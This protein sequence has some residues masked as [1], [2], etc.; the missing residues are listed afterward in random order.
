MDAKLLDFFYKS[1]IF[2]SLYSNLLYIFITSIDKDGLLRFMN[3]GYYDTNLDLKLD[4]DDE[5][6]RFCIQ[7]Y[8]HIVRN[9]NLD[10]KKV[11]EIGC[12]RGGGV[13]YYAKYFKIKEIMGIDVTRPA[14][15]F[16]RNKYHF[17][18]A[19]FEVGNA[20]DLPFLDES[21]DII[22][23]LE[24]SGNYL[25][26][27][28]FFSEVHRLLKPGGYFAYADLRKKN[29]LSTWEDDLKYLNLIQVEKEDITNNV[30]ESLDKDSLRKKNMVDSHVPVFFRSQFYEFS[31]ISGS[32]Y[33]Y[34]ALKKREKIYIRY[35]FKK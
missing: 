32:N 8:N 14:I 18:N 10:S 3:Y 11:L 12:G 25:H 16:C 28:N 9:I 2:K 7:L 1:K 26:I 4:P 15:N 29:E 30:T 17:D 19:E 21:Y 34:N 23:N 35:L 22:I 27:K 6:D 33:V 5:N 24:S 20:E 13:Y 31:G